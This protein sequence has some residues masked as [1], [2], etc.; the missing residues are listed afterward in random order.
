MWVHV[1]KRRVTWTRKHFNMKSLWPMCYTSIFHLSTYVHQLG[2]Q[3]GTNLPRQLFPALLI[4]SLMCKD[5]CEGNM[6][7]E[8]VKRTKDVNIIKLELSY[9][10][11]I[12]T[13][14]W[15]ISSKSCWCSANGIQINACPINFLCFVGGTIPIWWLDFV[16]QG[17]QPSSKA[18]ILKDP[19]VFNSFLHLWSIKNPIPT[20][21]RC[22]SSWSPTEAFWLA[23]A[24]NFSSGQK[25]CPCAWRQ[26]TG[27]CQME[28]PFGP[29]AVLF[30]PVFGNAL[31]LRRPP[32]QN[33]CGMLRW[34][35]WILFRIHSPG[36]FG[37]GLSPYSTEGSV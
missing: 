22:L 14:S 11:Y 30:C 7:L 6:P 26:N 24:G 19:S 8:V 5:F 29:L 37:G 23:G 17:I 12:H 21:L 25:K 20:R 31:K 35:D 32:W 36:W 16:Q 34:R 28:K 15:N 10:I 1:W 18:K 13:T 2:T 33:L 9:C 3:G 4:I 27:L